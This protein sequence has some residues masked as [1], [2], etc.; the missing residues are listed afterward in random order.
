M[1]PLFASGLEADMHALGFDICDIA[2]DGQEAIL[3]AMSD[4]PDVV[5]I[6][7]CL[8]GG[9]EGTEA[10]RWLREVSDVPIVFVTGYTDRDT[11]A[12]IHDVV[13]GAPVLPKPV[14]RDRL[15]DAIAAVTPAP[16]L[17]QPLMRILKIQFLAT[18]RHYEDLGEYGRQYA[19]LLTFAALEPRDAFSKQELADAT[20]LL[21]REG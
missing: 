17:Y 10:A 15:A 21:P 8:E 14:Y 1:N 9:R 2:A 18:A 3:L 6:D 7:V 13:P 5:L 19:D 12:R 4:Q 20:G 16:R 11:I